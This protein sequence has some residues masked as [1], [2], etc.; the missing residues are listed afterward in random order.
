MKQWFNT[1]N[2]YLL[3]VVILKKNGAVEYCSEELGGGVCPDR[4]TCCR[5]SDGSSGCIPADMGAYNATCCSDQLTGCGYGFR[6]DDQLGCVAE[7]FLTDPLVQQLPRYTLCSTSKIN[8]LYGLELDIEGHYD[9]H[10]AYYSSH[11]MIESI[12]DGDVSTAVF[13]VHGSGRNADDYFCTMLAAAEKHQQALLIAPRFPLATDKGLDIVGGGEVIQWKEDGN[14]GS[15]RY[16]GDSTVSLSSFSAFDALVRSVKDNLPS[17]KEIVVVGHSAGGQFVQRW[18]MLTDEWDSHFHAVVA[19]PSSYAYLTNLRLNSTSQKWDI[20]DPATCDSY[21]KWGWGFESG[22]NREVSY[23]S[24][25]LQLHG[26]DNLASRFLSRQIVYLSGERDVCT[27]T[28]RQSGWCYS[29]GLETTCGDMAQGVNRWE[30]GLHY[31]RSLEL[32]QVGHRHTRIPVPNVGHDH[33][34]M[35]N[36]PEATRAIYGK[37]VGRTEV[38]TG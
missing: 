29:H 17:L 4:N 19:N 26:L 18:S 22:G 20:P 35:L 10:L 25:A 37:E 38:S 23:M 1:F 5:R 11:G 9:Q 16:G 30:R 12:R 6:C 7:S 14:G 24:D 31:F 32:T 28:G 2:L 8:D 21:N 13:V 33:S 3:L 36:S 15:W 27:V 34:L